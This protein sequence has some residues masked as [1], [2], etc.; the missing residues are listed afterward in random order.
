M[1]WVLLLFRV[2]S[3]RWMSAAR[4]AAEAQL[5]LV[6]SIT[7]RALL[8]GEAYQVVYNE[9]SDLAASSDLLLLLLLLV[10]LS[11]S[12]SLSSATCSGHLLLSN[13]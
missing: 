5:L 10:Q 6:L 9:V 12:S 4:Q 11:V 3:D 13:C 2:G 8:A 1:F 7:S